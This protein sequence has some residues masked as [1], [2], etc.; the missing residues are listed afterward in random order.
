MT[1]CLYIDQFRRYLRLKSKVVQN[2]AKLRVKK[3]TGAGLQKFVPKFVYLYPCFAP[4][5]VD[6]FGE[7]IPSGPK[8]IYHN[9]LNCASI[10]EL[11]LSYVFFEGHP[12]FA[13]NF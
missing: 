8:V 12:N 10:F 9:T 6:K 2:R 1:A 7:V 5:H 4:H 13:H 3:F 11:V